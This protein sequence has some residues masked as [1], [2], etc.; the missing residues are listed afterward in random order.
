MASL[1]E[2]ISAARGEIEVDLLLEGAKVVNVLSGEIY[3]SDVVIHS[4]RIVGFDCESAKNVMDLDGQILSPGF[5]DAHVH[6]ESSMV[7]PAQYAKAVV[8]KG[9]TTVVADPHEIGNV[10]GKAGVQ[11]ILDASENIPLNVRVMA[12]SCVPATHLET[13]GASLG[14]EEIARLMEDDRVLGLA[15]MMNYP[16]VIFRDPVVLKKIILGQK[17]VV[18]GHAPGLSGRDLAAYISAGIGSD[19]ECTTLKEAEEKLRMGMQIMMREGSA[20]KNLKDLIPL[21]SPQNCSRF[22]FVSDDRH[23]S[24][25]LREGHIDHM[26]RMAVE[27]GLDPITAFQ[28]A[29]IN[30]AQY[31]GMRDVGAIAPGKRADMVILNDPAEVSVLGVIKDGRLVAKDGQMIEAV[32]DPVAPEHARN[33][34]NV[35]DIS[36][37]SPHP[38]LSLKIKAESSRARVIGVVPEQIV[39]RALIREVKAKRGLVVSD[40]ERDV[41]KMVVIERHKGSGNVGLGLVEGFGLECGAIAT[42]VAHDSHNLVMVGADDS[43]MIVA[44]K[45][46]TKMGG[47]LAVARRGKVMASLALPIAGLLSD[48]SMDEVAEKIDE[49]TSTAQ[50]LGCRLKDPF[51]TLSFLCLP[52]IPELKLTDKGLVDV[53]KFDFVDLFIKDE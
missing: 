2:L 51:M 35:G 38:S 52:V 36:P 43:D 5:V 14:L 22:C 1:E 31:F 8:P 19:H 45:Y 32:R 26:I 6:L 46:V 44:G 24:D 18:D 42:S 47:G 34:M 12:P 27:M 20:A 9:T 4:G 40:T 17:K 30:P 50:D 7:T 41:L 13:S 28:I 39:T 3:R 23:P 48:K 53:N 15:E 10:L 25:I 11:Y 16:G 29:T 37:L 21:V 33:T 49:V